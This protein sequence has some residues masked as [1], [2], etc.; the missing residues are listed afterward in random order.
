MLINAENM[1]ILWTEIPIENM[2]CHCVEFLM[3]WIGL[4]RQN[5]GRSVLQA[6][7]E[8]PTGLFIMYISWVQNH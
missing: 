2:R 4:T 3:L 5:P 7:P 8:H 1:L 6:Q